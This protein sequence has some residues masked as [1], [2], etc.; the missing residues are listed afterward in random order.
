M[1]AP[2]VRQVN[3]HADLVDWDRGR[4]FIG[5]ETALYS[6]WRHLRD[7]R[8]NRVDAEEPAGILTHHLVMDDATERFMRRLIAVAHTHG[9]R[10][11][12]I[13]RSVSGVMNRL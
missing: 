11:V 9:G 6:I 13:P 2:G 8:L 12:A 3:I 4:N 5:E 7:R 1:A 10:F